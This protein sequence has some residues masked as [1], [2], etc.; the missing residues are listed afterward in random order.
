MT[1]SVRKVYGYALTKSK[2][3]V[4]VRKV[5]GYALLKLAPITVFSNKGI[6]L[7]KS[8]ILEISTDENILKE[9]SISPPMVEV[10]PDTNSSIILTSVISGSYSG[11]FKLIYNRLP[12]VEVF[13]N[14]DRTIALKPMTSM[15]SLLDE[16]NLRYYINFTEGDVLPIEANGQ[17]Q[18][19]LIASNDSYILE[20]GTSVVIGS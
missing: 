9:V 18:V 7:V 4:N 13:E 11:A 2:D 8:R 20:P 6:E 5:Y 16:I 14:R 1:I 3:P 17:T 15:I 19:T 12:V 10:G